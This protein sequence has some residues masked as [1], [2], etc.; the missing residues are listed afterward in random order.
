[1]Q[2][3]EAW[4][5]WGGGGLEQT[6]AMTMPC[7]PHTSDGLVYSLQAQVVQLTGC[8]HTC[9]ATH[10]PL[11]AYARAYA[12]AQRPPSPQNTRQGSR[13]HPLSSPDVQVVQLT[14]CQQLL[15]WQ[16]P[17]LVVTGVEGV[18][19]RQTEQV[20]WQLLQQVSL[21]YDGAQQGQAA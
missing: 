7:T 4:C 8:Q 2:T 16:C 1:M 17:Q 5:V 9:T 14:G 3:Q 18:Q 15:V 13:V 19:P 11:A 12:R 10:T 21:Q 20:C 6:M